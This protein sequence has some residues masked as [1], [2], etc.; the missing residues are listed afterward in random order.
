M[1]AGGGT[2]GGEAV[3]RVRAMAV[4]ALGLLLAV[5]WQAP[6]IASTA[7]AIDADMPDPFVLRVGSEYFAYATG[8]NFKNVQLR[9]ST[10]LKAWSYV[11]DV[12]PALPSWA[13]WGYTWAPSVLARSG[14][15]ALF[16]TVRHRDSGR[17]C[18]SVA[19]SSVPQGPFTDSSSGPLVC[20]L[21]RGGSI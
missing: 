7:P 2:A 19:T 14:G 10:D 16:Y 8:S 15:Y 5:V 21:D 1:G 3:R 11:R 20:Q 6:A 13:D 17:Q 4:A 18:V 12:L 9:R